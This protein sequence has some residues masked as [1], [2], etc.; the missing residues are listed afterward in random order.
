MRSAV[1]WYA[2]NPSTQ[3]PEA[4]ISE[5]KTS[6]LYRVSSKTGIQREALFQK[7]KKKNKV[8]QQQKRVFY[9]W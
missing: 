8:K 6:L 5:F 1:V 3:K 9:V 7:K 2:F 4:S